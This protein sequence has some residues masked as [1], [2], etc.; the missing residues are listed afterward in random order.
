MWELGGWWVN[1]W[2]NQRSGPIELERPPE[3]T[4]ESPRDTADHFRP[5]CAVRKPLQIRA[6][7]EQRNEQ[8]TQ[9]EVN[10]E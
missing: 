5:G 10:E 6:R 7:K 2:P 4:E 9:H 8:Q 1:G 3:V